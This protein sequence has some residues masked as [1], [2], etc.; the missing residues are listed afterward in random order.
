MI[1]AE[2]LML[3]GLTSLGGGKAQLDVTLAAGDPF[4]FKL[5]TGKPFALG[6]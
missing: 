6:K 1:G 3:V 2:I 5:A 4:L